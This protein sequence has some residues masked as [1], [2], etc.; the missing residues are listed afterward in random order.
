MPNPFAG[1]SQNTSGQPAYGGS[2]IAAPAPN[3]VPQAQ[4]PGAPPS[5]PGQTPFSGLL[6]SDSPGIFG[7]LGRM[8]G[9]PTSQEMMYRR[10]GNQQAEGFKGLS[11]RLARGMDQRSA[12]L[13]FMNNDPRAMEAWGASADPVGA[14]RGILGTLAPPP[15]YGTVGNSTYDQY[16]GKIVDSAPTN[17]GPGDQRIDG[18]GKV[19]AQNLPSDVQ[20]LQAFSQFAHMNDTQ[21]AELN[22]QAAIAKATT[23]IGAKQAAYG[24]LVQKGVIDQATAAKMTAG[25]IQVQP[26]YDAAGHQMGQT[27]MD[28]TDFVQGGMK[29]PNKIHSTVVG[30]DNNG[31]MKGLPGAPKSDEFGV[32]LDQAHPDPSMILA[33][34]PI[35]QLADHVSAYSSIIDPQHLSAEFYNDAHDKLERVVASLNDL[36]QNGGQRYQGPYTALKDMVEEHGY[37]GSPIQQGI[38][39]RNLI[40]MAKSDYNVNRNAIRDMSG[41]T[42]GT[43]K[44]Q[45]SEENRRLSKL[46]ALLP[47]EAANEDMIKQARAGRGGAVEAAKGLAQHLGET[48]KGVSDNLTGI[49]DSVQQATGAATGAPAPQGQTAPQSFKTEQEVTAAAKAGG[50]ATDTPI[51]VGGRPAIWKPDA[52]KGKK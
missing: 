13:D 5:I 1:A 32:P 12:V 33:A 10:M 45:A 35:G 41:A 11:E 16:T 17:I 27:V 14:M 21:S 48:V 22:K 15:H 42:T 24:Q 52:P 43:T 4:V 34:G 47:D 6:T 28:L 9:N 23:D 44:D 18:Q 2:G 49:A 50:W 25:L 29:D 3:N 30:M 46:L 19:I 39:F 20:S 7:L 37:T 26:F 38:A 31:T 40:Q 36:V 51:I 8:A